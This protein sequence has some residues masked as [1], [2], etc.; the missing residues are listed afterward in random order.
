[1]RS[2]LRR[3]R[4]YEQRRDERGAEETRWDVSHV[5]LRSEREQRRVEE[6]REPTRAVRRLRDCRVPL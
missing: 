5:R 1:M 2:A 6:A 3:E 4:A